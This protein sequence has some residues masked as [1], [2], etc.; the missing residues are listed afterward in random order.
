MPRNWNAIALP[1]LISAVALFWTAGAC[2]LWS[3]SY[4]Y[5]NTEFP[6]IPWSALLEPKVRSDDAF[7]QKMIRAAVFSF[8]GSGTAFLTGAATAIWGCRGVSRLPEDALP[9]GTLVSLILLD[10]VLALVC[11][12]LFYV[13]GLYAILM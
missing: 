3:C 7:A 8:L 1:T 6:H 4:M 13:T 10:V 2:W 5:S 9:K 11:F 12:R